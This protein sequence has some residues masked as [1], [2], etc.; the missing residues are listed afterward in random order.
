VKETIQIHC[1]TNYNSG[2]KMFLC[3]RHLR[4]IFE[5]D[6]C[7][8]DFT[9]CLVE[10]TSNKRPYVEAIKVKVPND[11]RSKGVIFEMPSGIMHSIVLTVY[12]DD[13][14]L[15]HSLKNRKFWAW[16]EPEEA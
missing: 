14:V 12:A 2:N 7:N 4:Q 11:F 16:V 1:T 8:Q 9:A 10:R 6:W 15:Y 13:V 3:E 5:G